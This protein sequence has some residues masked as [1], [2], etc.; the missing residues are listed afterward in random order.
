VSL[1]P[2]YRAPMRSRRD[3]IPP[4]AAVERAL[5]LGIC[6]VGGRLSVPPATLDEA[7]T[8]VASEH[9]ERLARRLA[10][11]ASAPEGAYI[12]TRDVDGATYLGRL[13]GSWH[14]DAAADAAAVD[15]V[16]VRPCAWATAPIAERAVPPAVRQTFAR[17]GRNWQQT[18]D[19]DVSAQSD[20]V[21]RSVSG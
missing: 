9:D 3:D 6:G 12:W 7:I 10:R 1:A 13:G 14:Y 5:R 19:P 20:T 15:L 21:W 16:H 11:F 17:G 2:V 8:A 18:H 4:G